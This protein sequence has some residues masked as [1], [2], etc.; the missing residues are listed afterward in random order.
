MLAKDTFCA[1][2]IQ[3]ALSKRGVWSSAHSVCLYPTPIPLAYRKGFVC[4][5]AVIVWF[6]FRQ[7]FTSQP[8]LCFVT[9]PHTCFCQP[10][11]LRLP[12]AGMT[13]VPALINQ[14][15][16]FY[17]E[18]VIKF[19]ILGQNK[20]FQSSKQF[21]QDSSVSQYNIATVS[22]ARKKVKTVRTLHFRSLC[23]TV[24]ILGR[25]TVVPIHPSY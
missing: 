25:Q 23:Q 15:T 22:S 6:L 13:S 10:S 16:Q 19:C 11:C 20:G 3:L 2:M 7:D 1:L 17:S 4:F 8:K 9:Q 18:Y 14:R 24:E 5:V 12:G 21:P